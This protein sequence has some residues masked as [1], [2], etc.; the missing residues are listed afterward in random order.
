MLREDVA[1]PSL[2]YF[3]WMRLFMLTKRV[4][5]S[6]F[7][8]SQPQRS[9]WSPKLLSAQLNTPPLPCSQMG[10]SNIRR[11]GGL[12]FLSHDIVSCK[13]CCLHLWWGSVAMEQESPDSFQPEGGNTSSFG[14][15]NFK[16]CFCRRSCGPIARRRGSSVETSDKTLQASAL[17]LRSPLRCF[18]TSSRWGHWSCQEGRMERQYDSGSKIYALREHI[19]PALISSMERTTRNAL[20]G[21]KKRSG[22]WFQQQKTNS[23]T[24]PKIGWLWSAC[25]KT[26]KRVDTWAMNRTCYPLGLP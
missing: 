21:T 15:S 16:K 2:P 13:R 17:T 10:K 9:N 18:G 14:F 6:G 26:K 5:V 19:Y 11:C 23:S 3:S 1:K 22:L 7:I 8:G 24:R 25:S 20:R 4:A 12:I